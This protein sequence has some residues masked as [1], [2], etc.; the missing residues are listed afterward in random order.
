MSTPSTSAW[1]WDSTY[2]LY[3]NASTRQ[4][5][6]PQPDGSWRYSSEAGATNEHGAGQSGEREEGE[7]E[8]EHEIPEEQVWP[9]TDEVQ[10]TS[11]PDLFAKAPLLRLVVKKADSTVLPSAQRIA[12]LD[13]QEPVTIGRD[14]SHERRIRLKELAVSKVHATL[15]WSVDELA[16]TGGFWAIVDNG[17]THGTFLKGDGELDYSRLSEPKVASSPSRL[18]HVDSLRCG[19]TTFIVHIHASFACSTCTVASDSSNIIPLLPPAIENQSNAVPAA[20]H[21]KTKEE[22][23]IER[24]QQLRGLRDQFL[25]PTKP[26]AAKPASTTNVS[27]TKTKTGSTFVDR[28]AARRARDATIANENVRKPNKPEPSPF[29]TVPGVT[30]SS[31]MAAPPAKTTR[32]DPFSSE[33]RGAQLLSKMSGPKSLDPNSSSAT[34]RTGLGTL[35]EARTFD[36]SGGRGGPESRPGL[37]SRPLVGIESIGQ[38]VSVGDKRDW[39]E[40]VR[41]ASRKRFKDLA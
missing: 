9:G 10:D 22:K 30:S 11:V 35:I 5:A 24:R 41:E 7:L 23:E 16:E 27:P 28:A 18:H 39:R 34:G 25:K 37:G 8:A 33:S 31:T 20:Y 2:S 29:F 4:W 21:T 26:T 36:K 14:R 1:V 32:V 15:F 17:S 3:Y 38:P 6:A 12:V 40:D 19:S 13:P